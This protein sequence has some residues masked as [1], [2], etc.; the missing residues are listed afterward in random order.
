M[1]GEL[2]S[3]G[4]TSSQAPCTRSSGNK[5]GKLECRDMLPKERSVAA[6]H[7]CARCYLNK[8]RGQLKHFIRCGATANRLIKLFR[9]SA[10]DARWSLPLRR[11]ELA[12]APVRD[13][14][15]REEDGV[16]LGA[17]ITD[18]RR[19][20]FLLVALMYLTGEN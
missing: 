15:I 1:R 20:F 5:K 18:Q 4:K 7:G 3:S 14:A 11:K 12:A 6:D 16:A 10:I 8:R 9:I 19:Q 17:P 13:A 2:R